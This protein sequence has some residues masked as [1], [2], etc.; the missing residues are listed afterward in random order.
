VDSTAILTR[1]GNTEIV[2]LNGKINRELSRS[3]EKFGPA[4]CWRHRIV[5]GIVDLA[6]MHGQTRSDGLKED[7]RCAQTSRLHGVDLHCM[8]QTKSEIPA[9]SAPAAH[10]FTE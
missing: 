7:G 1:N 6:N 8:Q 3:G 5:L 10:H 2:L 4:R 9:A